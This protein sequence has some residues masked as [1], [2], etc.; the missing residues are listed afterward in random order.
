MLRTKIT[1][2]YM[3]SGIS[4]VSSVMPVIET[5]AA[6]SARLGIVYRM[7]VDGQDRAVGRAPADGDDGQHERDDEADRRPRSRS[8]QMCW[9]VARRSSSR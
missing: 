4:T 9:K 7:S 8:A 5:S 3:T 6:K 2:V 1:S